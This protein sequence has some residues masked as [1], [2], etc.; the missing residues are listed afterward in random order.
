MM[1]GIPIIAAARTNMDQITE[2]TEC[3]LVVEYGDLQDIESAL[4]SLADDP[5]LRERLGNNGRK[6]YYGEFS[7][8]IMARRLTDLYM[9]V[10][11]G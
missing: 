10:V 5:V 4:S 3:G 6:A 7:W 1:L 8:E 11:E 9:N 2:Q